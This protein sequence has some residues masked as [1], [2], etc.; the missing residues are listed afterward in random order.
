M[1]PTRHARVERRIRVLED[2]LHARGARALSRLP[3]VVEMSSPSKA[4]VAAVGSSSRTSSAAERGLAAAAFADET[5]RLAGANDEVDAVDRLY[6]TCARARTT[7]C[8]GEVPRQRPRDS[9]R[10]SAGSRSVTQLLLREQP[11]TNLAPGDSRSAAAVRPRGS[12]RA[13]ARTAR[14][15]TAAR[16]QRQRGR[17]HCPGSC[18]AAVRSLRPVAGIEASRPCVYGCSGAAEQRG[19]GALL[20]DDA[21]IHDARRAVASLGDDAEIMGDQQQR[22]AGFAP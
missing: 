8:N 7:A 14:L 12:A 19:D 6:A 18:E 4:I 5:Q 3:V 15:Q 13:R 1:S 20:D 16:G 17:A 9:S 10:M 21:G 11:A 2:N 22:R